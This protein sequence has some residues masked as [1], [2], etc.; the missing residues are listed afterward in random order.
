MIRRL[1]F[2]AG[3]LV[4]LWLLA[5]LIGGGIAG[6]TDVVLPQLIAGT[7]FGPQS[8]LAPFAWTGVVFLALV[9]IWRWAA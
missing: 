3:I 1:L 8:E 4:G 2:G 6:F 5:A 9:A 7:P